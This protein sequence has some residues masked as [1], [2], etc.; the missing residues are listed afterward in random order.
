MSES[1]AKTIREI[2][3][4]CLVEVPATT[5][6]AKKANRPTK[7]KAFEQAPVSKFFSSVLVYFLDGSMYCEGMTGRQGFHAEAVWKFPRPAGTV[8]LDDVKIRISTW[9]EWKMFRKLTLAGLE[10]KVNPNGAVSIGKE[11]V[12][13]TETESEICSHVLEE[14]LGEVSIA[15]GLNIADQ[16][17]PLRYMD[18][19]MEFC[20]LKDGRI[21]LASTDSR[22][23]HVQFDGITAFNREIRGCAVPAWFAPHGTVSVYKCA[24]GCRAVSFDNV[25]V[26]MPHAGG[27]SFPRIDQVI[28]KSHD[29]GI[30]LA[31]A[32]DGLK[33]LCA[34]EFGPSFKTIIH[35][36]GKVHGK[37]GEVAEIGVPEGFHRIGFNAQY[38]LDAIKFSGTS[39]MKLTN[40]GKINPFTF[41]TDRLAVVMP[42]Q[43]KTADQ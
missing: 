17:G 39:T 5:L 18:Y 24:D 41:G 33:I 9:S 37:A 32:V 23:L 14:C 16:S 21:G 26:Y 43:I 4:E 11:V 13:S 25:V 36:D 7:I 12:G 28:P 35:E 40:D 2:I 29:M 31:D 27:G 30:D 22:R 15:A 3:N 1:T 38:A 34:K 6:T 10:V 42:I 20:E 19:Y 8:K